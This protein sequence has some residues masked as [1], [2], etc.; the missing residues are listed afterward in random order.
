MAFPWPSFDLV[1]RRWDGW[2]S[3][4]GGDKPTYT[5]CYP[6]AKQERSW[7][8]RAHLLYAVMLELLLLLGEEQPGGMPKPPTPQGLTTLYVLI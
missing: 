5:Q 1:D 6:C 3:H 4:E 8:T 2:E 7:L